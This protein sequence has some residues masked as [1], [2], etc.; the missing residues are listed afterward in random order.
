MYCIFMFGCVVLLFIVSLP[1]FAGYYTGSEDYYT[2][3]RSYFITPLNVT[4]CA[5]DLRDGEDPA[6]MY[7]GVYSTELFSERAINII[8]NHNTKTVILYT[9]ISLS[10][11]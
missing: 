4:R 2:H 9:S 6:P 3:Q 11:W 7:S 1:C 5:L 8:R 10:L